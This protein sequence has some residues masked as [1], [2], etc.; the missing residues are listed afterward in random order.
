MFSSTILIIRGWEPTHL[1]VWQGIPTTIYLYPGSFSQDWRI[2][3]SSRSNIGGISTSC[4]L[5]LNGTHVKEGLLANLKVPHSPHGAGEGKGY[6]PI[7]YL[8]THIR[9]NHVP[10]VVLVGGNYFPLP[11][12]YNWHCGQY[13]FSHPPHFL[14]NRTW[15]SWFAD[16]KPKILEVAMSACCCFVSWC[17]WYRRRCGQCVSSG[18]LFKKYK[19]VRIE[20]I[21]IELSKNRKNTSITTSFASISHP[22]IVL[23]ATSDAP[24]A[25]PASLCR[26]IEFAWINVIHGEISKK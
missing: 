13:I 20:Q 26:K 24:G 3:A 10:S 1:A 21:H 23:D 4:S 25:C 12:K 6:L 8:T 5:S 2:R 14:T 11:P 9:T 16:S 18:F 22:S 19:F 15:I 17:S 7:P